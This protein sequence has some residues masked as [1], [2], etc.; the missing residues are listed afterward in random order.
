MKRSLTLFHRSIDCLF[1]FSTNHSFIHLAYIQLILTRLPR[2]DLLEPGHGAMDNNFCVLYWVITRAV[3]SSPVRW[4][5][6]INEKGKSEIEY[7]IICNTEYL[8]LRYNNEC[9]FI[10]QS[11]FLRINHIW[12]MSKLSDFFSFA[13]ETH[14]TKKLHQINRPWSKLFWMI[15]T[16]D[17][18]CSESHKYHNLSQLIQLWYYHSIYFFLPCSIPMN[19]C[20]NALGEMRQR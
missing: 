11:Y 4:I 19:E 17:Q 1:D 18:V 10:S 20:I 7:W 15:F 13:F 6:K 16:I 2:I 3:T 5:R 14:Q 8:A 9:P 12:K